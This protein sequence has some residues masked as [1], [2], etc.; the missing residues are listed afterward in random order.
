MYYALNSAGRNDARSRATK[1]AQAVTRTLEF[2]EEAA[3]RGD[4]TDALAWLQTIEA[5]DRRLPGQYETRREEWRL[6][7]AADRPMPGRGA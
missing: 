1:H 5:V 3:G 4:F 2:A 6:A 7:L